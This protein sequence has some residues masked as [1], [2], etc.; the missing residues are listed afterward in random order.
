[1]IK[2]LLKLKIVVGLLLEEDENTRIRI[3]K[4]NVKTAIAVFLSVLISKAFKLEYP[5][6][7]VIAAIFSME[8]SIANTYKAG[9]YRLIGTLVGAF[10][11]VIFVSI[12]PGNALLM[13]IGTMVL[14]FICNTFKWDRA[15]PIAGVMF[16]AIMLSLNNKNPLQYSISR[17]LDTCVGIVV[18][19]AVNY[20]I[21]PPNILAQMR[22][23]LDAISDKISKSIT[24][25]ICEGKQ[26]DLNGLR[27][28]VIDSIK[29]LEAYKTEFNPKIDRVTEFSKINEKLESLRSILSHLKTVAELGP[30]CRL[31]PENIEM[32][33]HLNFC[34]IK[35]GEYMKNNQNII[36]NYHVEKIL[37][38]LLHLSKGSIP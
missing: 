10:T 3:G 31:S 14:I 26:I 30:Q 7:T 34:A 33:K 1:V 18:A 29:F 38:N 17:V 20:F 8:N 36:F 24:E 35:T 4:R 19:I 25:F 23:S 5:F 27:S 37:E 2:H 11:G 28:E 12:Q 13:G 21:F 22:K 6:F 9:G 32:L 15:V 16:A